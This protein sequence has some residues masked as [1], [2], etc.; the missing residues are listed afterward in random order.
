MKNE[1]IAR[2]A[3]CIQSFTY[4]QPHW[5]KHRIFILL[6][7]YY[8]HKYIV[9]CYMRSKYPIICQYSIQYIVIL[10]LSKISPSLSQ[11]EHYNLCFFVQNVV[12]CFYFYIGLE[13]CNSFRYFWKSTLGATKPRSNRTTVIMFAHSVIFYETLLVH[14]VRLYS[15]LNWKVFFKIPMLEDL[16]FFTLGYTYIA[17]FHYITSDA[18][19]MCAF[20]CDF[21]FQHTW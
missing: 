4:T 3:Q 10:T 1:N 8:A 13:V 18:K 9:D 11:Y 5:K 20:V 14:N 6:N 17:N 19:S 7:T 2:N 15:L 12:F 16:D 21:L